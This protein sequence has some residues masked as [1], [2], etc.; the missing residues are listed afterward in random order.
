MKI[1]ED[2]KD[3]VKLHRLMLKKM[4]NERIEDYKQK[5]V[6]AEDS[7]KRDTMAEVVKELQRAVSGIDTI[8]NDKPKKEGD[9]DFTGV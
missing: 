4:L 2:T 7:E 9:K 6:D 8:C 5:M 1:D 3:F